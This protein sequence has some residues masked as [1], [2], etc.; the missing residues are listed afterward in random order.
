MGAQNE[1]FAEVFPLQSDHHSFHFF[2]N[3]FDSGKKLSMHEDL[4]SKNML[5]EEPNGNQLLHEEDPNAIMFSS[6]N[7]HEVQN[8]I[9]HNGSAECNN[10]NF[11]II[12]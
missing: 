5:L 4:F 2:A 11:N 3:D 7:R 10:D 12:I 1:S 8:L 6:Q 9:D